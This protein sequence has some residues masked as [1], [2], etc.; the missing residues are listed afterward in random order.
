MKRVLIF[1]LLLSFAFAGSAFAEDAVITID[2]TSLAIGEE[3]FIEDRYA[4]TLLSANYDKSDGDYIT[5]LLT[6][7]IV[8][9]GF[10]DL[11][12]KALASGEISIM[13]RFNYLIEFVA[14][15]HLVGVREETQEFVIEPLVEI[16]AVFEAK[17]P[18]N[19]MRNEKWNIALNFIFGSD[20]YIITIR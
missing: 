3:K 12:V 7:N 2:K 11:D 10:D 15:E 9:W 19:A 13:D 18:V 4:F 1:A 17:I 5:M 8:N 20:E 16:R 6:F 14:Y